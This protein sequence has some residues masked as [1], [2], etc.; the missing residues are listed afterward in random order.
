MDGNGLQFTSA[1]GD[2]VAFLRQVAGVVDNLQ[3]RGHDGRIHWR[4]RV[5]RGE[6]TCTVCGDVFM[7]GAL[8]AR[9]GLDEQDEGRA[10]RPPAVPTLSYLY[11]GEYEVI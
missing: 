6:M 10:V 1:G 7:P 9:C 2:A 4:V 11:D 5:S 8:C 3:I